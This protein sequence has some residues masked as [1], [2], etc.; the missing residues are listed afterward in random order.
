MKI[1]S[2]FLAFALLVSSAMASVE[3]PDLNYSKRVTVTFAR[4][5][6]S[7]EPYGTIRIVKVHPNVSIHYFKKDNDKYMHLQH[8]QD[9]SGVMYYNAV[10]F[11]I[12]GMKTYVND[13]ETV[14]KVMPEYLLD[15]DSKEIL[16]LTLDQI[17]KFGGAEAYCKFLANRG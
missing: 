9:M 1:V 14:G 16:D 6:G 12:I 13:K 15:D 4:E 2:L 5:D 7:R 10:L 11:P 8:A 3:S 17:N